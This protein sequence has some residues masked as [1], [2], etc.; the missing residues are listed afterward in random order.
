MITLYLNGFSI[1]RHFFRRH[2]IKWYS[3][4]SKHLFIWCSFYRHSLASTLAG[5]V[6]HQF[7]PSTEILRYKRFVA[8]WP[9]N[10]HFVW[11]ISRTEKATYTTFTGLHFTA[12]VNIH[13]TNMHHS[14][15]LVGWSI[16]QN[17]GFSSARRSLGGNGTDQDIATR[18][19]GRS[20]VPHRK[21][22]ELQE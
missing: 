13:Y 3:V 20:R 18:N 1:S 14:C 5:I 17:C 10:D 12:P 7:L 19:Q 22:Q 6:F 2:F 15:L 21:S 11:W 9:V 8:S 16:K 4:C